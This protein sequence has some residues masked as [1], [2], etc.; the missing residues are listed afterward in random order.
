MY[1]NRIIISGPLYELILHL[2]PK[3]NDFLLDT[4][5]V[6]SFILS[7]R[8][9]INPNDLLGKLL[10]SVPEFEPLDR[11]VALIK[12]WSKTFPYDFRDE[13]IMFHVKHIVAKCADTRLENEVSEL[14]RALLCRLTELEHH[15]EK[16]RYYQ[17]YTNKFSDNDND[18]NNII[19]WPTSTQLAQLLCRIERKYAKH[20]GPEEF[21]QCSINVLHD[22]KHDGASTGATSTATA[23]TSPTVA[24]SNSSSINSK[25]TCNLESYL[26]WSARL[27]LLVSNEI[28]KVSFITFN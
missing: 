2:L 23:A 12:F 8:L 20:V 11:C 28:L 18:D 5:Y 17:T 21:V 7:S 24:S 9:F 16:L 25:K 10:S 22:R 26:D 19:V 4:N 3:Q 13:T 6:F 14:L 1:K 27:K 15:E